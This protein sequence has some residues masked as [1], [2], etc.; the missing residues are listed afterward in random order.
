M[1]VSE[2]FEEADI[3]GRGVADEA[4]DRLIGADAHMGLKS[5]VSEALAARGVLLVVAG[6]CLSC[7]NSLISI[8]SVW[9]RPV[10]ECGVIIARRVR[11]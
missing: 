2:R 5:A 11:C 9:P 8:G 7:G 4:D 6:G 3:E 10:G 1:Q